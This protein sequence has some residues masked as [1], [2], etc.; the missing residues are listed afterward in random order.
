M[1][2][3]KSLE[4]ESQKLVM[5]ATR[6]G[7][8]SCD[9]VVARGSSTSVGIRQGQVENSKHS[10]GDAISL[11]VFCGKRVA[12]VTANSNDGLEQLAERAVSMAKVSPE[13]PYQ[14]LADPDRLFDVAG[15]ESEIRSLDLFDDTQIDTD[16]MEKTALE[17]EKAGLAVN[18]VTNSMGTGMSWSRSGFVLATSDG[19]VG[20]SENSGFSISASMVAGEGTTMERDYDF[21]SAIHLS[22]LEDAEK[23][24]RSAGERVVRRIGPRQVKSGTYPV[25]F[26]RRLSTG[27][28]GTMMG[29]ISGA[30]V[31]RKTSFL[32]DEM[33]KAIAN[34]AISVFDDPLMARKPASRPFDGEGV[35]TKKMA[36]V[37]E[38]VLQD[39]ILDS[40]SARELS[41]ETNGRAGRGGSSTRPTTTNCFMEAGQKTAE[42]LIGEIEEGLYLTETIGH[43]INM[44]TGDYS[45]GAAGFWI[46]NGEVTHPVAE[47]TVAGNLV[48]MFK[49][50]TPANDLEF[51]YSTNAPTLLVEGM[52]VGGN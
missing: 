45:K 12:S 29:A 35:A 7:A 5:L 44:V 20:S 9:V 51:R 11:R 32:R 46:K 24:G 43:G 23:I 37:S 14:G 42:E 41:L 18:G 40:A 6:A 17:A 10:E 1:S 49:R 39:W 50:I 38:G 3:V 36:F 30:A 4:A 34:S 48:D 26:D 19:F 2:T 33:G 31:A 47:I 25:V 16:R 28:L 52:T 8:D 15:L 22:D 27:L 21:D 13:D